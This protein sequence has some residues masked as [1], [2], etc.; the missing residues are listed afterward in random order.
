MMIKFNHE[1]AVFIPN[2]LDNKFH[3]ITIS[4]DSIYHRVIRVLRLNINDQIIFFD[5]QNH[6]T[7]KI[8]EITKKNFSIEISKIIK[9]K[10][11][12]PRITVLISILK[13]DA[14]EEAIYSCCE[15]G[16]NFI[17]PIITQKSYKKEI[18]DKE[19]KRLQNII[20]SAAEQSK[21]FCFPELSNPKSLQN[22][23]FELQN[24]K[25]PKIFFDSEGNNINFVIDKINQNNSK[26][27]FLIIGPEGDLTD[28]EKELVKKFNFEFCSLTP[29]ILRAQTAVTCALSVF[30]SLIKY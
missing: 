25:D 4:D 18:Q 29:T 5:Q 12:E 30:R 26:N 9:N 17:Q 10:S 23:L 27:I 7:C 19:F 16:A 22:L 6:A 3:V 8:I 2:I 28:N 15:L 11:I 24:N 13:T 20:I 1:F 21:N 14:M